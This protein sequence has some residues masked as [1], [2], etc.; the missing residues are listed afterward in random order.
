MQNNTASSAGLTVC[1]L[2]NSYKVYNKTIRQT[3]RPS[4]A[5]LQCMSSKHLV[6]VK[7]RSTQQQKMIWRESQPSRE[8]GISWS[9][10]KR[11]TRIQLVCVDIYIIYK[12]SLNKV[13][14]WDRQITSIKMQIWNS[15][16]IDSNWSAVSLFE[17]S[18]VMVVVAIVK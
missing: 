3:E 11:R 16:Y 10:N 6:L 18:T 2:K 9:N 8:V 4:Q 14:S 13:L 1:T 12:L 17:V 5:S 7:I 15:E